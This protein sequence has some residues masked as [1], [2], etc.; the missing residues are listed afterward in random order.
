MI[1]LM[2]HYDASTGVIVQCK[3]CKNAWH[4]ECHPQKIKLEEALLDD[5]CCS[6]CSG[7]TTDVCCHCTA[8]GVNGD[9]E[10][11]ANDNRLV[12]CGGTCG[13]LWHQQC[14]D[15][16]IEW[17]SESAKWMC[18]K[19]EMEAADSCVNVADDFEGSRHRACRPASGALDARFTR[20]D[21]VTQRGM[22]IGD[23]P[24]SRLQAG[25]WDQNHAHRGNTRRQPAGAPAE[26]AKRRARPSFEHLSEL[27]YKCMQC[28]RMQPMA[29]LKK[30]CMGNLLCTGAAASSCLSGQQRRR[31][32]N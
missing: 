28:D 29:L 25:T 14:H 32:N 18:T 27:A 5:W 31:H 4:Q 3:K 20:V 17:R 22:R 12:Y 19:C 16:P 13:R 24:S 10:D 15:P 26:P 21:G 11:V 30:D 6:V 7:T 1:C 8:Q 9:W 2:S 23:Q